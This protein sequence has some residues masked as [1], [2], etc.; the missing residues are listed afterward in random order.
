MTLATTPT[1]SSIT[2]A[3]SS[4][5]AVWPVS[6]PQ[7]DEALALELAAEQR[8][9]PRA[10]EAERMVA[11]CRSASSTKVSPSTWRIAPARCRRARAP[12]ARRGARS[13]SS[14]SSRLDGCFMSL[15]LCPVPRVLPWRSPVPDRDRRA[16]VACGCRRTEQGVCRAARAAADG[17]AASRVSVKS[18]RAL[19]GRGCATRVASIHSYCRPA[20]RPAHRLCG[21]WGM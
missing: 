16:A 10:G 4:R 2:T 3:I 9:Q 18:G 13:S 8:A 17:A 21:E 15:P 12:A 14:N 11:R 5:I 19:A 7:L 1:F 6:L 20:E